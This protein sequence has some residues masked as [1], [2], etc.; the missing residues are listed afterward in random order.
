MDWLVWL[1]LAAVVVAAIAVA[2]AVHRAVVTHRRAHGS[3]PGGLGV[4]DEIY[5]PT[6][7]EMRIEQEQREEAGQE[8]PAPGEPRTRR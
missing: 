7:H 8:A 4:I 3:F 5:R 1:G 6:V 2:P